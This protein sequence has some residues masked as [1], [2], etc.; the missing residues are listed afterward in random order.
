MKGIESGW[1]NTILPFTELFNS[2]N[3]QI[4][5][6]RYANNPWVAYTC[7]LSWLLMFRHTDNYRI[8]VA[9]LWRKKLRTF[10]VKFSEVWLQ[11]HKGT[12]WIFE[13]VPIDSKS[14]ALESIASWQ[15]SASA[16]NFKSH[17]KRLPVNSSCKVRG[18]KWVQLKMRW[19][20]S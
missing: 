1:K 19:S 5:T 14:L 7:M 3:Y 13:N 8:R 20:W 18:L 17:N 12:W 16:L 9:Q 11:K 6:C 2:S 10:V 15:S 4:Q